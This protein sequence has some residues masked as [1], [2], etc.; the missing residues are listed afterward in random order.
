MATKSFEYDG[1]KVSKYQ[2]RIGY[3]IQSFKRRD[4]D[5]HGFTAILYFLKASHAEPLGGIC[6]QKNYE[7]NKSISLTLQCTCLI[8]HNTP[9][10]NCLCTLLF[11]NGDLL[12]N[13]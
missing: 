11:Q 13:G 8:S 6:Q 7:F 12:D 1:H 9:H 10:W 4:M 2:V 5:W 3:Q